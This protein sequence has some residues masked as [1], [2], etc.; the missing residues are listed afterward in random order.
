MFAMLDITEISTNLVRRPVDGYVITA[1]GNKIPQPPWIIR[2]NLESTIAYDRW[3]IDQSRAEA[4]ELG[5]QWMVCR[6]AGLEPRSMDGALRH[7][8]SDYLFG[9]PNPKFEAQECKDEAS[10]R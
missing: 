9:H 3:L 7:L 10:L 1:S 4:T 6:L 8:L 2:S 5:D